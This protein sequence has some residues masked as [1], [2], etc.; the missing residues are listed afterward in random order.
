MLRSLII[1][2][3][4]VGCE[5]PVIDG[6]TTTT[7]CNYD[8]EAENDD[9]SCEYAMENYDCDGDCIVEIDCSDECGGDAVLDECGV[10][11]GDAL[12]CDQPV[13]FVYNSSMV[14]AF[15]FFTIVKIDDE[16]L[17][18]SDWVGAFNNDVCVGARQWD[19]SQCQSGK[20]DLPV[21]GSDGNSGTDGYMQSGGI[22]TFKIFDASENTYYDAVASENLPWE[23]NGFNLIES[24]NAITNSGSD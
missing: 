4:I 9:G 2:L 20:C 8:A 14:Q 16:N 10:C 15:Y 6:C 17:S 5:E 22:P 18:P 11:D 23:N 21:M 1:L 13:L 12:N 19:T 24:L 3:L 7:A